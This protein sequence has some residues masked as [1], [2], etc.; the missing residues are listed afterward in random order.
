[1]KLDLSKYTTTSIL[2]SYEFIFSQ[3]IGG[4]MSP[5]EA[6]EKVPTIYIFKEVV[7]ELRAIYLD[8]EDA[9][10]DHLKQVEDSAVKRVADFAQFDEEVLQKIIEK[11]YDEV[12]ERVREHLKTPPIK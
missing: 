8:R 7:Q 5:P 4:E 12:K 9:S 1:M 10:P 3:W 6:R 11:M 2:A